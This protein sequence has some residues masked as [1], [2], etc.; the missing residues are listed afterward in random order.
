MSNGYQEQRGLAGGFAGYLGAALGRAMRP[1]LLLRHIR[2][3]MTSAHKYMR[4]RATPLERL[5]MQM[6]H[7][8]SCSD[9]C[10]L[11][12]LA[13]QDRRSHQERDAQKRGRPFLRRE[14]LFG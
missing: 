3:A 8:S 14:P 9:E 4:I 11:G 6:I 1:R 2:N 13:H 12:R 5:A 10:L 7:R